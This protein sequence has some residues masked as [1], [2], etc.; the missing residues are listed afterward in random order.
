MMENGGLGDKKGKSRRGGGKTEVK[1]RPNAHKPHQ[2]LHK[3]G[4]KR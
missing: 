2:N 1:P 3:T 4:G